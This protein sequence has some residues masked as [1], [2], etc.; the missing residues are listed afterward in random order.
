MA[1]AKK[2]ALITG[3]NKGIGLETARQ[4]GQMGMAVVLGAR[5]LSKGEAAAQGLRAEGVDARAVKLD[6]VNAEDVT[7]AAAMVEREFGVLDA[8][9]NNAGVNVRR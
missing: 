8:L 5:D 4:L 1:D 2:V 6:V 9:V 3:A 7:A